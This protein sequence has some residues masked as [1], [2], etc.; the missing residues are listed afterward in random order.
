MEITPLLKLIVRVLT[1][2]FLLVYLIVLAITQNIN[3]ILTYRYM[4]FTIVIGFVHTLVQIAFTIF[5]LASGQNIGGRFWIH[6]EFYGDKVASH[7]LATGTA[8]SFGIS[9]VV[10]SE[11]QTFLNK[12]YLVA[13]ILLIAFLFSAI[14][15]IFSSLSLHNRS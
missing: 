15:S 4:L 9:P 8:A 3:R 7:L 6:F 13:S 10:N 5:H 11:D 1:F 12:G 2:V 14:S